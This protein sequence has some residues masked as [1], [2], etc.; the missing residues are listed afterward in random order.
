MLRAEILE[1]GKCFKKPLEG[2]S[3]DT[4]AVRNE[5]IEHF[6]V[7][8]R[9]VKKLTTMINN[10]QLNLFPANENKINNDTSLL[11][12]KIKDLELRNY[13]LQI[14]LTETLD[15]SEVVKDAVNKIKEDNEFLLKQELKVV[16]ESVV[17]IKHENQAVLKEELRVNL[18]ENNKKS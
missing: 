6:G 14:K 5:M 3:T 8:L 15:L 4:K 11:K 9:A 12:A 1:L 17:K 13:E 7:F 2:R 10:L 18:E 16:Q